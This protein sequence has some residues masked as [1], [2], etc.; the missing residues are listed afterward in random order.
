MFLFR[1]VRLFGCLLYFFVTNVYNP[2]ERVRY[3]YSLERMLC[4]CGGAPLS[5]DHTLVHLDPW[6]REGFVVVTGCQ[7][8]VG[9][10]SA[11]RY[12]DRNQ[13]DREMLHSFFVW[14]CLGLT[15]CA[16]RLILRTKK[17]GKKKKK[18]RKRLH[19]STWHLSQN[20]GQILEPFLAYTT[21]CLVSSFSQP[22]SP[23]VGCLSIPPL[24]I[25]LFTRVSYCTPG[26]LML[27]N[28]G[29]YLK[30]S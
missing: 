18:E 22:I 29:T 26:V 13:A 30:F 19:G 11:E 1:C 27:A 25:G 24:S 28:T 9:T 4:K 15:D 12:R 17:H 2:K 21:P 8:A 16:N 5:E 23:T 10:K 7:V 14:C 6:V 3:S 20:T